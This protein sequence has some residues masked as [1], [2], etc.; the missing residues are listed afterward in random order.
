M[1]QARQALLQVK[2]KYGWND[3]VDRRYRPP[4]KVIFSSMKQAEDAATKLGSG[5]T[6]F[7]RIVDPNTKEIL[8]DVG[9]RGNYD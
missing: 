6:F 3:Y 8:R 4:R 1:A 9:E 5:S 7:T 2:D